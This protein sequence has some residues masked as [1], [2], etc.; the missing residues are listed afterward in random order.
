MGVKLS[1]QAAPKGGNNEAR[2]STLTFTHKSTGPMET[3]VSR[4]SQRDSKMVAGG[5]RRRSAA[6]GVHRQKP[7]AL[8]GCERLLVVA[9]P[10]FLCLPLAPLQGA[11]PVGYRSGGCAPL[12]PGYYLAAPT[13][14]IACAFGLILSRLVSKSQGDAPG[15][16]I[17]GRCPEDLNLTPMPVGAGT[18][19]VI[20]ESERCPF[21]SLLLC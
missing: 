4:S 14:A 15:Y 9:E 18:L 19:I 10:G 16:L 6:P 1:R 17:P 11:D 8:K 7:S 13:G 5:K 20:A 3:T 21:S 2:C 12:T